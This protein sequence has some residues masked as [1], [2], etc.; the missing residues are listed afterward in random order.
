MSRVEF[1]ETEGLLTPNEVA[2][3]Y[4]VDRRTVI[5]WARNYYLDQEGPSMPAIRTPGGEWRLSRAFV[6]EAG[7]LRG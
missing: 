4:R 5:S 7:M 3:M 1:D 6:R 2:A